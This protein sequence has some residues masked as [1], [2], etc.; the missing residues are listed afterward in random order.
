M[1][2]KETKEFCCQ[3]Y[4]DGTWWCLNLQAYD[5]EDAEARARKLGNLQ[6]L[7]ELMMTIPAGAGRGWWP[8][9]L[10][11]LRNRLAFLL[12]FLLML[13]MP[14]AASAQTP[15]QAAR[16][17]AA[18]IDPKRSIELDKLV[19]RYKRTSDRYLSVEK[20]KAN[21]VPAPV[22]FALFYRECDNDFTRSP[23]QGDRLTH[24]SVNV[25]KG[26]IPGKNPPFLWSDA[27]YDAYYV[28]DKLDR[29]KWNDTQSALD[30]IESFNG[31]GY[32]PK[33][34]PSPYVWG[35]TSLYGTPGGARGKFVADGRFDRL[36]I[37]RQLGVASIFKRLQERG[38]VLSFVPVN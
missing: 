31:F 33:G 19:D 34:I 14:M 35:G 38:I 2:G 18:R 24:R 21:G 9:A 22:A 36:A 29:T 3:Y 15:D 16:W 1:S 7:G 28:V 25:P 8:G 6:V 13:W 5:E 32:R 23:A 26:R 37:D 20:M 11:W 12:L 10:C 27:A 4:H 17:K 30:K